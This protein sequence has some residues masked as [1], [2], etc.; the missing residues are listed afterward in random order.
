VVRFLH[1]ADWQIGLRLRWIPG[2][3]GAVVREARLETLRTLGRVAAE[4]DCDFVVVAGDVF[5]HHGLRPQTLRRTFDVLAEFTCPIYLLPGNHDPHT[6]DSLYLGRAWR[7]APPTVHVLG[8][9]DPVEAAPDCWLLPCPLL[10]RHALDDPTRHLGPDFGPSG[11]VRVGVA[12]GGVFELLGSLSEH[13]EL[14]NRVPLDT[15]A[16]GGLDYLALGDWHS[17]LQVDGRTWYSG[18]PEPTRFKERDP[19]HAL[20]VELDGPGSQPRVEAVRVATHRW[21]RHEAELTTAAHLAAL[22]AELEALPDKSGTLLELVLRGA[23]D[24]TVDAELAEFL[25]D[26]GPRLRLLRLRDEALC[27]LLSDDDLDVVATA[28]WVRGAIDE[29]RAQASSDEDA[30]RALRLLWQLHHGSRR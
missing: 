16:R 18:A 19:G 10:E 27:P 4:R 26:F 13:E 5:E 3:D 2:D 22:E 24:A 6:A 8:S 28:G 17:L 11:V 1:T 25:A 21:L 7:H 12:H 14:N 30:A 29:L 15:V 9:T 23:P 20:V